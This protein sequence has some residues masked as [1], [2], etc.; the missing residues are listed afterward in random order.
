MDSAF[1]WTF[2][3]CNFDRQFSQFSEKVPKD[4]VQWGHQDQWFLVIEL[5]DLMIQFWFPKSS[6]LSFLLFFQVSFRT[7]VPCLPR[8]C[9]EVCQVC[10]DWMNLRDDLWWGPSRAKSRASRRPWNFHLHSWSQV[11][12]EEGRSSSPNNESSISFSLQFCIPFRDF[13]LNHTWTLSQI[14]GFPVLSL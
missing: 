1:D 7:V 4:L 11:E 3:S 5:L 14:P 13:P 9:S 10:C 8:T 2:W 12:V 6:F